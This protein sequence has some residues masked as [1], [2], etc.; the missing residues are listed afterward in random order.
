M[1]FF[2]KI[3]N[4]D[5]RSFKF[6]YSDSYYSWS[7]LSEVGKNVLGLGEGAKNKVLGM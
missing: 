7:C 5:N 3:W 1:L 6:E 2:R 4:I